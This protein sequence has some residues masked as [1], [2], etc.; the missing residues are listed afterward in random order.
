MTE[1]ILKIVF[2]NNYNPLGGL[3]K[4]FSGPRRKKTII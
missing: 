3:V 2:I 1:V 4:Y